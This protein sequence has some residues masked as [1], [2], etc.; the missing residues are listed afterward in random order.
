MRKPKLQVFK[1]LVQ[2][3]TARERGW[4][5]IKSNPPESQTHFFPLCQQFFK[6]HPTPMYI[7]ELYTHLKCSRWHSKR[8]NETNPQQVFMRFLIGSG[9][10]L[11][12]RHTTVKRQM[13]ALLSL[14]ESSIHDREQVGGKKRDSRL[15]IMSHIRDLLSYRCQKQHKKVKLHKIR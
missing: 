4:I 11:D 14:G 10:V 8:C 12:A 2:G 3:F 6:I 15:C 9:T 7:H 5:G 1:W 13:P